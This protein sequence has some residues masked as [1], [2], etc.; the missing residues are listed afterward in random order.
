MVVGVVLAAGSSK[1]MGKNKLLLPIAGTSVLEKVIQTLLAS[2][3]ERILLVGGHESNAI[4]NQIKRYPVEYLE[5]PNYKMGQSTSI[6]RAVE[7]L[8]SEA[9]GILFVMADQPLIDAAVINQMLVSF[10]ENPGRILVPFSVST[11]K[12]GAPVLF[13]ACFFKALRDLTGDVG[14]KE[15]ILAYPDSV[16]FFP[17]HSDVFFKDVDTEAAYEALLAYI[18]ERDDDDQA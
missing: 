1:R 5:N 15:V 17:V 2:D 18:G 14:G 16:T 12:R 3:L 8:E 10:S 9:S 7:R 6:V 13:D 4:R 11:G